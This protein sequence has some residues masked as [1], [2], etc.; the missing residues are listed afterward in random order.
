MVNELLEV[1][2]IFNPL[3]TKLITENEQVL[4]TS[5]V[6]QEFK[7]AILTGQSE[8]I[9]IDGLVKSNSFRPDYFKSKRK[10]KNLVSTGFQRSLAP[11]LTT[12]GTTFHGMNK[13]L[14]DGVSLEITR[15]YPYQFVEIDMSAAH[16]RVA[17]WLQGPDSIL[18][19]FLTDPYFWD[20]QVS[21]LIFEVEK[22]G[23]KIKSKYLRKMLKVGFYT[24]LNGGNPSSIDRLSEN[25]ELNINSLWVECDKDK[26]QLSRTPEYHI[27]RKTLNEFELNRALADLNKSCVLSTNRSFNIS[28]SSPGLVFTIDRLIP[29]SVDK[30]HMGISRVLQGFEVVMLTDLVYHCIKLG[31]LPLSLDHD[32][33]FL[34]LPNHIEA[35]SF[36]IEIDKQVQPWMNYLLEMNVPIT[37]K[38]II[39]EGKIF[40]ELP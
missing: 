36:V 26:I 7:R 30:T 8:N 10:F 17:A 1:S 13:L 38:R 14:L 6:Y 23:P 28:P 22:A 15:K 25:F 20:N 39:K 21:K 31:G 35:T 19:A 18:H 34:C 24:A 11:R 32:G 9:Y 27:M 5:S 16:A 40:E 2:K 37:F 3:F 12:K 33:I 4:I 29:Y